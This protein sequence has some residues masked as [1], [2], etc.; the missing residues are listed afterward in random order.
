MT[1]ANE[2]ET[3][4]LIP[5]QT[6]WIVPWVSGTATAECLNESGAVVATDSQDNSRS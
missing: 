4:T 5:F 1:P 3:D 2:T 6:S